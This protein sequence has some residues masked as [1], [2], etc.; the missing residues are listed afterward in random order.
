MLKEGASPSK[1]PEYKG[2]QKQNRW[3]PLGRST[4]VNSA[5]GEKYHIMVPVHLVH[6]V[7]IFLAKSP[8]QEDVKLLN[9]MSGLTVGH[10]D[11][12]CH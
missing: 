1:S 8:G 10:E 11:T 4:V 12:W 7:Q 9:E 3:R 5:A 2:R 6:T